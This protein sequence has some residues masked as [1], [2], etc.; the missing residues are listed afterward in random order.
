MNIV[1]DSSA[2]T[3]G[4]GAPASFNL[5]DYRDRAA[6][7]LVSIVFLLNALRRSKHQL[8]ALNTK[9][10]A[11]QVL[12]MIIMLND[13]LAELAHQQEEEVNPEK[14]LMTLANSLD[15]HLKLLSPIA[16][17]LIG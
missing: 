7:S 15:N 5:K 8:M 4:T 13:E 11:E 14:L 12:T 3:Q 17:A 9:T 6:V 1:I 16:R 2:S 10:N